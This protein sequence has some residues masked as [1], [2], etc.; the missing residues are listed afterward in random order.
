VEVQDLYLAGDKA[1]ASKAIP[2]ELVEQVAMVGPPEKIRE[3]LEVWEQ[4]VVTTLLVSGP[5]KAL[6]LIADIV[7]G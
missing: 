3:E 1:A 6:E 7:N 5:P 4:T 2:L